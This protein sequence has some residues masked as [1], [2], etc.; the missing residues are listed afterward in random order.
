[1]WASDCR[2]ASSP[3]STRKCDGNI[4]RVQENGS[5]FCHIVRPGEQASCEKK[6]GDQGRG[7]THLVQ[8]G[9][10][11]F[12][13]ELRVHH[14]WHRTVCHFQHRSDACNETPSHGYP[15]SSS[16]ERDVGT[17]KKT[18]RLSNHRNR[19]VAFKKPTFHRSPHITQLAC[20]SSN[21]HSH[22][23]VT[24]HLHANIP[25]DIVDPVLGAW[26]CRTS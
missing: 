16:D 11:N 22:N 6:G 7:I 25:C 1:M 24:H 9:L 4:Q 18:G 21:C 26:S 14:L 20:C 17:H 10:V 13:A 3:V 12:I 5:M 19:Q 15:C 23:M 2:P 8:Q